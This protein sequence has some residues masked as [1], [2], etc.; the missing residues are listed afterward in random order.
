ME[1]VKNVKL[2]YTQNGTVVSLNIADVFLHRK[3]KLLL[4]HLQPMQLHKIG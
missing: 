3:R 2:I 1:P 4:F